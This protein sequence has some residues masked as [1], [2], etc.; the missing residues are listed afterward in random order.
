MITIILRR[1]VQLIAVANRRHRCLL[2]ANACCDGQLFSSDYCLQSRLIG[3]ISLLPCQF[4][5]QTRYFGINTATNFS[6]FKP[7]N[8]NLSS[9]YSLRSITSQSPNSYKNCDYQI[10]ETGD[11]SIS[12]CKMAKIISGKEVSDEIRENL[13]KRVELLAVKPKL[14][15]VQ[16]GGRE[17]SN[18][19]IRMKL[20]FAESIGAEA[21]AASRG[22]RG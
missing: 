2:V 13:K 7:N 6:A 14:A 20:R 1:Q 21:E 16:V 11:P 19:Y 12:S 22:Y 5:S 10:K 8:D 17:D 3:T 9:N 18:V 15:I 4:T